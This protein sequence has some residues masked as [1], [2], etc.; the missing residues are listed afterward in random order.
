MYRI[1]HH[2]AVTWLRKTHKDEQP[3]E[4]RLTESH[5]GEKS[6]E[7]PEEIAFA[8]FEVEDIHRALEQLSAPHRAVVELSYIHEFTYRE[9]AHI[10]DCPEGTVKSRMNYALQRLLGILKQLRI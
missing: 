9:I 10:M 5:L 4:I 7:D 1:A 8:K 6:L 2:K 3:R